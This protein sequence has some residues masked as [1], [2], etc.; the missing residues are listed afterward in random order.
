MKWSR[1]A[2]VGLFVVGQFANSLNV[3]A[4]VTGL[5]SPVTNAETGEASGS[6]GAVEVTS[7]NPHWIW[8][9]DRNPDS[10]KHV[11]H[12]RR[13]FKLPANLTSVRLF[14]VGDSSRASFSLNDEVVARRDAFEA[15][16]R[17][18]VSRSSRAGAIN[19]LEIHCVGTGG[20]AAVMMKLLWE[21][22]DGRQ[23]SLVSDRNWQFS[24]KTDKFGKPLS[25]AEASWKGVKSYGEVAPHP[26]GS[27]DTNKIAIGPQHDYTQWKRAIAQGS[28]TNPATFEVREGFRV[29]TIRSAEAG[30]ESWV[31]MTFDH[32]GR[33]IIGQEKQGL[34][35]L[36]MAASPDATMRVVKVERIN[37]SLKECRGL[38]FAGKDLYAMANNDKALFR[39]RDTI[40]NDQF[41]AVEKI[42]EFA[43]DVGHGRN[44]IVIGPD[45][46]LYAIFGDSVFE[47]KTMAAL[48][49]PLARPNDVERTR[50]GFVA[51]MDLKTGKWAVLLRGLRNPFGIALN[52]HGELF[53]YDADAE[54]D[55]GA[56]WYRPTRVHHLVLGGDYGWRRVT[57]RWPPYVPDRPDMPQPTF[58]IGKGSPTAVAFGSGDMFPPQYQS[59]LFVLDWS[60]GRIIAVHMEPHGAS[61]AAD[62]EVFLRGEPLNVTDIEFGP[63][64]AMYFTT[65]GRGTQSGLY[66]VAYNGPKI[67]APSRSVQQV[68][69]T[70]HAAKSREIRRSLESKLGQPAA[71]SVTTA[72]PHLEHPD[73]WIRHAARAVLEWQPA[74]E[75]RDQAIAETS[76]IA[77]L[78]ALTALARVGA[79]VDVVQMVK[80]LK[81]LKWS[82]LSDTQRL[83]T[84]YL[85]SRF[86]D[87]D[88]NAV[89]RR[90]AV[91]KLMNSRYPDK[92]PIVNQRLGTL[93]S[94]IGQ[95][96]FVS[97]T[98][99]LLD[100]ALTDTDRLHWLFLLRNQTVGWTGELRT[101]YGQQLQRMSEFVAAEGMP[102]FQRL[103][104]EEAIKSVPEPQRAMF[105]KLLQANLAEAWRAEIS[106]TPR[107]H[108]RK[109]T[110]ADL[111]KD[112][113]SL[114]KRDRKR[115]RQIFADAKCIICHRVEGRGGVSGP[116]LDAVS[117]RFTPADSLVSILEPSK[118][119]SEKYRNSAFVLKSGKTIIG[120]IL[121]GD[122]R[123]DEIRVIP[124]LLEPSQVLAF[125]K[126]TV[127][128]HHSSKVSPM[129]HGLLDAFQREEILD[130]LAYLR[131][132]SRLKPGSRTRSSSESTSKN[133]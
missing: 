48:P 72:W 85:C 47:P 126:A 46:Q 49:P 79:K 93:L 103:I 10:A 90:V 113:D 43:G 64:G 8:A 73:P 45:E 52:A 39:L 34:L 117:R 116:D 59:A 11:V 65:G 99:V 55:M 24:E 74:D 56:P 128:K 133:K 86:L 9:N 94:R 51:K 67:S 127:E 18:D 108:V 80:R 132:G 19:R 97:R 115:G 22:P 35:R 81:S 37:A 92:S 76:P 130:L 58:D 66:R 122:Y 88:P 6:R 42:M 32:R 3:V 109:W 33:I 101:L 98:M 5:V 30:E 106:N 119:V 107:S 89:A 38:V 68:A 2:M 112:L 83:E 111:A 121:P 91:S 120:R 61:Y 124:N 75:W 96:N 102:D 60:Y 25:N 41:D 17:V 57:R 23:T 13:S 118:I 12:L 54:Y 27:L 87:A 40:G 69:R 125:K 15:P 84:I 31:S 62:A 77:R 104:R 26:W 95:P 114:T 7:T 53:T 100:N 129:P 105:A 14:A 20:P 28:G 82:Q 50:S 4:Q 36:T 78:A 21:T 63:D 123:S 1:A 70:Q 16:V 71:D 44:Q 131:A 29:S 110:V